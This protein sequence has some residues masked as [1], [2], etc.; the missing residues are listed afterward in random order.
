MY[1]AYQLQIKFACD[2]PG[3]CQVPTDVVVPLFLILLCPK[4][5]REFFVAN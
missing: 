5:N 3:I 1:F 2:I 4:I